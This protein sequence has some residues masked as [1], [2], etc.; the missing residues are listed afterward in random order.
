[1]RLD[2]TMASAPIHLQLLQKVWHC[3]SYYCS[4]TKKTQADI[5]G[6][7][8]SPSL[9]NTRQTHLLY[10][11]DGQEV[12]LSVALCGLTFAPLQLLLHLAGTWL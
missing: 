4:S 9:T 8:C 10:Q 3:R 2:S 11:V 1:M 6:T 12:G 5:Q 7:G